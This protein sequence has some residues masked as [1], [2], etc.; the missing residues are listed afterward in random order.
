MVRESAIGFDEGMAPKQ[1]VAAP[2]DSALSQQFGEQRGRK[3]VE[4]GQSRKEREDA[5]E[6]EH[7]RRQRVD[8]SA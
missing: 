1:D 7:G 3:Q 6:S 8:Q 2:S 4:H 5:A